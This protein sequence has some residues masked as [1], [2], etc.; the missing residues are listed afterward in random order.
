MAKEPSNAGE[1]HGDDSETADDIA[2]EQIDDVLNEA[3]DLTTHPCGLGRGRA[4]GAQAKEPQ[5]EAWNQ[6]PTAR[7]RGAWT[8]TGERGTAAR[9]TRTQ[10]H[11][12]LHTPS[13]PAPTVDRR[14][15]NLPIAKL[16]SAANTQLRVE[17]QTGALAATRECGPY[18]LARPIG[19]LSGRPGIFQRAWLGYCICAE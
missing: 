8:Q 14:S 1:N 18:R 13:L 6:G 5:G 16:N 4:G 9:E 2:V 17:F 11:R 10:D 3:A 19:W 12:D 7:G 15:A